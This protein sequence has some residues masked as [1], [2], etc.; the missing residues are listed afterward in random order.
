[1]TDDEIRTLHKRL[2]RIRKNEGYYEDFHYVCQVISD[3]ANI[4]F[5][6]VFEVCC[7]LDPSTDSK[8]D[9][10]SPEGPAWIPYPRRGLA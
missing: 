8:T 3:L 1:M 6:R 2:T 10:T 7:E 9:A 4:P 5:D